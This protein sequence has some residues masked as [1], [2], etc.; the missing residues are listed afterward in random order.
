M[1]SSSGKLLHILVHEFSM[2]LNIFKVFKVY[3][4]L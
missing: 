4:T 1:A 3:Y 2:I